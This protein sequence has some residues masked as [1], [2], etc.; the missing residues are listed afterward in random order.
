MIIMI[1]ITIIILYLYIYNNNNNNKLSQWNTIPMLQQQH[2]KSHL[3]VYQD[4]T[5]FCFGQHAWGHFVLRSHPSQH[6]FLAVGRHIP[7]VFEHISQFA[8]PTPLPL[9]ASFGCFQRFVF[10]CN[11]AAVFLG[12]RNLI[13]KR[14]VYLSNPPAPL[15]AT[16]LWDLLHFGLLGSPRFC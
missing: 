9:D 15:G 11:T 13:H 7:Q 14:N 1:I 5:F 16:R 10:Q 8:K 12:T 6:I 3:L 2:P 4:L